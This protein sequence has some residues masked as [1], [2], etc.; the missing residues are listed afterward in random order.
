MLY[1]VS[2][3]ITINSSPANFIKKT[4]FKISPEIFHI[5]DVES[6][7]YEHIAKFENILKE[8]KSAKERCI[9]YYLG[10]SNYIFELWIVLHKRVCFGSLTNRTE[11]LQ[12]INN[13]SCC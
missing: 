7:E 1:N 3:K 12:Y 9:K 6:K 10:Y 2:F 13:C 8:M 4:S 11:Y 5:C